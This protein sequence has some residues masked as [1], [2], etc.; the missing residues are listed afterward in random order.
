[1]GALQLASRATTW[2]VASPALLLLSLASGCFFVC[3]KL[4]EALAAISTALLRIPEKVRSAAVSWFK[5]DRAFEKHN[6]ALVQLER[7]HELIQYQSRLQVDAHLA[8]EQRELARVLSASMTEQTRDFTRNSAK[9]LYTQAKA[10]VTDRWRVESKQVV[11]HVTQ[12]ILRFI[13]RVT[14]IFGRWGDQG[15]HSPA[16]EGLHPL[17]TP[18]HP[19]EG[20][21][22]STPTSAPITLPVDGELLPTEMI[23]TPPSS[24]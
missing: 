3:R 14:T 1:M 11:D 8:E 13:K 15:G 19:D 23:V 22:K 21:G 9:D 12:S 16:G 24:H 5:T 17:V 7:E 18:Q 2:V 4:A 6:A 20:N 10:E